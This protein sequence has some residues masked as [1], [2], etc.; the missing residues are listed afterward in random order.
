MPLPAY[1]ALDLETTGLN[2]ERDAIIEVAAVRVRQG[3]VVDEFQTLVRPT[4]QLPVRVRQITGLSPEALAD[5]PAMEEVW[6]AVLAFLGEDPLVGHSISHDLQFLS[7]HG[8]L[9]EQPALDTFELASILV[10]EATRYTLGHLLALLEL[11]TPPL[12]RA[13]ADAHAH[14]LLF[15]AL[16]DRARRLDPADLKT[17]VR[18]ADRVEWDLG[19][20][21]R[22]AAAAPLPAPAAPPAPPGAPPEPLRPAAS[23]RP[24]DV[25]ALERLIAPG[26][27]LARHLP[28]FE[29]RPGQRAMLREVGAVL[30]RGDQLFVEAGTGTGKSLAYLLPAAAWSLANDRPVVIATHTINLQDQ[31][32]HKDLPLV[33]ELLAR[34]LRVAPLKGR[35]NYLCRTRL[36]SLLARDDLDAVAVR[37]AA[38][39]LVWSRRTRTG[40]R[41]ELMLPSEEE[42]IW[43][44]VS[45]EG[46]ACSAERCPEAQIGACWLQRA[47]ARAAGAH[48]ILVNH[49]LLISDMLVENRLLPGYDHLIIDEA[50]HLE[51]VAT[52]VLGFQAGDSRIREAVAAFESGDRGLLARLG[53]A[54]S[55]SGLD[56]SARHAL[57]QAIAQARETAERVGPAAAAF[58]Q[59]LSAFTAAALGDRTGEVRLT[60]AVRGQPAWS[61]IELAWEA[62]SEPLGQLRAEGGRLLQ[63]LVA[64]AEHFGDLEEVTALVSQL[65]AGL[66]ELSELDSGLGRIVCQPQANDITWLSRGTPGRLSL[67]LAPLEVGDILARRL[68]GEK[69]AVVLTSATL[70]AGE[71]FD[72]LAGRL[73]LPDARGQVLPSPFDFGRAALVFY[74]TD[75]PEPGQTGYQAALGRALVALVGAMGGRT[76]VLFTAHSALRETYHQIRGPLG[77]LGIAVIGQGLDGSRSNLLEA[78]RDPDTRTALLGTRSFWEGVDVPGEALSCVVIPRLPFDV[79]TDPIFAARSET[80]EDPFSEYAVPQAV[81]RFRQGFGRLIRRASDR[82]V[83]AVLDSRIRTKPYGPAFLAALPDCP[84]HAGPIAGVGEVARRFLAGQAL[85][86]Q[87][88]RPSV[89]ALLMEGEVSDD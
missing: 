54:V 31:L 60:S 22:L 23:R 30:N 50:H 41:A 1:V 59:A 49:A 16:L 47:R 57:G 19:L 87:P 45:A 34:P 69:E 43:R 46:D 88:L 29:D 82:G 28:G 78:L 27:P 39:I 79:P 84:H 68:F 32:W 36:A 44:Q 86:A 85:P 26:G 2:P 35:S 53:A 52:E 42:R 58:Q 67:K 9:L 20:V 13:L 5:A 63:A 10:P 89:A 74:P 80:C 38:K 4:V 18:L 62:V 11:P 40:D 55:A 51:E 64:G 71:R 12:H 37:A 65:G 8:A 56:N 81:L 61:A 75:M 14:H 33:R 24:V 72:F 17:I 73:G 77:E 6:A 66:R 21:F 3:R 83:V 15:A 25:A 7:R 76:L 70:R 48:L